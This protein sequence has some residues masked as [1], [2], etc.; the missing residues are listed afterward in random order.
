MF[1]WKN[2]EYNVFLILLL[3]NYFNSHIVESSHVLMRRPHLERQTAKQSVFLRIQVR[4]S[5][6]TKGL[7]RG[8][9][10]RARLGRDA[11]NT[12]CPFCI[13]CFCSNEW[14]S[15]NRVLMFC[16]QD[17]RRAERNYTRCKYQHMYLQLERLN[18][19][20]HIPRS[21]IPGKLV[22]YTVKFRK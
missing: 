5:C 21:F 14:F 13:R 18:K 6:Q 3:E 9:K 1:N 19:G 16:A 2:T 15:S 22:L 7:E 8:W 20:V 11:K 10:Q 12:D 4:A 17:R